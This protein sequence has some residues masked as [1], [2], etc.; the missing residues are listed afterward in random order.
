MALGRTGLLALIELALTNRGEDSIATNWKLCTDDNRT[1]VIMK[2][3]PLPP[4]GTVIPNRSKEVVTNASTL[5]ERFA[6]TP[7]KHG[8]RVVGWVQ[9]SVPTELA[10]RLKQ[11]PTLLNGTVTVRDYLSHQYSF[12]INGSNEIE[13]DPYVPGR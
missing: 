2:P 9:F 6:S 1:A 4:L 10:H 5:I 12:Y 13:T 8:Q 7:I 11:T 3:T